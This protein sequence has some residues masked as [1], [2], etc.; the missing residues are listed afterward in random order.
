MKTLT[1]ILVALLIALNLP[2][3]SGAPSS[4]LVYQADAIAEGQWWRIITH[5]FVH[6]GYYHLFLD[7]GA[8]LLLWLFRPAPKTI[9]HDTMLFT[10]CAAGSLIAARLSGIPENGFCGLS[11]VA[12]G[13]MAYQGVRWLLSKREPKANRIL[14]A[15]LITLI[16]GKSLLETITGNIFFGDVHFGSVGI[17]ITACHLGGTAGGVLWG[18]ILKMNK[19][20]G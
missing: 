5:P 19:A 10:M 9:R 20:S 2:L 15:I 11:G 1:P 13:L 17:P 12:H 4:S 6:V 16:L 8:F 3:L 18:L 7:A 14:G